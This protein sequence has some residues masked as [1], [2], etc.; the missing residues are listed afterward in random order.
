LPDGATLL[1]VVLSSDKTK[2]SNFAGNCYAH[3]LLIILANIDPN[4]YVKGSLQAYSPLA[5]LPVAKFIHQVKCMHNVLVDRLLHQCIDI[6][7]EPLKQAARL[8]I[9]MSDPAGLS[10]YYFHECIACH[11]GFMCQLWRP[12]PPPSS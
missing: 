12:R 10:R 3:P 11:Y 5:L 8:G 4:V 7:I 2:V 1:G 9:M 6:V